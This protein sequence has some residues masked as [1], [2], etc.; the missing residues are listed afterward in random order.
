MSPANFSR[1]LVIL[2]R[3]DQVLQGGPAFIEAL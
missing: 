2:Q 1:V 3:G